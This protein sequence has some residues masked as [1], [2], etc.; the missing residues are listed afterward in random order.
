[1]VVCKI[2]GTVAQMALAAQTVGWV[3]TPIS[4]RQI[5]TLAYKNSLYFYAVGNYFVFGNSSSKNGM[6][7][8]F[9]ARHCNRRK[10]SYSFVQN[11]KK[12]PLMK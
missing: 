7:E 2:I 6:A 1:V 10:R 8:D 5:H 3:H 4:G 11:E 12:D 9:A